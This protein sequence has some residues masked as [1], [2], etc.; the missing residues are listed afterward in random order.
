VWNHSP[1]FGLAV[2]LLLLATPA[3]AEP[4]VRD[5]FYAR[6]SAGLGWMDFER[7]TS[8]VGASTS[9]A[10]GGLG[11]SVAGAPIVGEAAIGGSV[12]RVVFAGTLHVELLSAPRLAPAGGGS[13]P[14]AGPLVFALLAPTV[15]VVSDPRGGLHYGLGVGLAALTARIDDPPFS[16]I[17]GLGPGFTLDAGYDW[18]TSPEWSTGVMVRALYAV[19]SRT[20]GSGNVT[21]HEQDE[22]A[23]ICLLATIVNQ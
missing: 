3:G 13:M 11:S 1:S 21:G 10:Y 19:L 23:S 15:D 17:G 18:F 6:F 16:S 14:L 5:G 7:D 20:Q 9:V 4:Y 22:V 2:A 8:Q 12:S